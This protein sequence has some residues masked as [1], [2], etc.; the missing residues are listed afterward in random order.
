MRKL[1]SCFL[2][3]TLIKRKARLK[4]VHKFCQRHGV[5][6]LSLQGESLS[7]DT[8]AVEPFRQ[9]LKNKIEA[10]GYSKCQIFN[11]DETGLWW[12]LMPSRSLVESKEK[13][14]RNFKKPKDRVTILGCANA[15]GTCKLPLAFIHKSAK[16]RCFK[17]M[18]MSSLPV[19]YFSQS[20]SWMN[21]TIFG[22][23]FHQKFVPFV[24]HFCQVHD[25]EYKIPLLLDNAPSH[26]ST[27]TL[28]SADGRVTT[29]FLPPNCTAV[30]QP[31][32]QGILEAFKRRY[33]KQ[34]LRHV[35]LENQASTLTVPEI[36]KKLNIKDAV[37][38]SAQAWEE[39]SPLSLS[40]AWNKLIPPV[41]QT[42]PEE[43]NEE[44]EAEMEEIFQELGSEESTAWQSPS[45][46]LTEDSEDPGYQ[47]MTDDEIVAQV[48]GEADLPGSESEEE[49]DLAP[50]VSHARAH[51]AFGI[52][53][54]WLEAQGTDPAHL[55]LVKN[56]MTI[57][58]R[59]RTN[60]LT[61]TEITSF[62][63][64]HTS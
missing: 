9:Q 30:L 39:A 36:V 60:S 27:E 58:G 7:A 41:L 3:S 49:P 18:D 63:Q 59:K 13:Q 4:Q 53:L 44:A 57:A 61:Q 11:A 64:S 50:T 24:K 47:L 56:W 19:S 55:L 54:Q 1:Y 33:K 28:T 21:A 48:S 20:K 29:S 12:R 16:P 2:P 31:M 40:K 22:D 38:W 14:A 43:S 51:E 17:H 42:I 32:D 15:S 5:R 10:E 45:E 34:L 35:I 46:W 23:W 52:A 25:I 8:S 37:Y 62:F 6:E 26:P